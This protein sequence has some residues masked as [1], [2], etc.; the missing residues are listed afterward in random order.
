MYQSR[1]K[2]W[3][4]S[5]SLYRQ[6]RGSCILYLSFRYRIPVCYFSGYNRIYPYR[7]SRLPSGLRLFCEMA[8]NNPPYTLFNLQKADKYSNLGRTRTFTERSAKKNVSVR[9]HPRLKGAECS[10]QEICVRP[11]SSEVKRSRVLS[12]RKT[13][14]VRILPRL[15][16]AE[17]S[18]QEKPCPSVFIRG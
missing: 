9:V 15:K 5:G 6:S 2:M 18:L 13:V 8:W 1:R 10:L 7:K 14:S 16:G 17:C 3:L 12:A 11:C 4:R